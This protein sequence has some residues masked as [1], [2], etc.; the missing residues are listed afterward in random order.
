MPPSLQLLFGPILIGNL[1]NAVL[2]GV[3]AMQALTY[4]QHYRRDTK[5][6]R[7]FILYLFI[8]ETTNTIFAVGMCF[9]PLILKWAKPEAKIFFPKLLATDPVTTVAIATPIQIFTAN[10]IRI[11]SGNHIIPAVVCIL[12][13]VSSGG[14]IWLAIK[15]TIVQRFEKKP[16][17]HWAA[18]C[19]LLS[20]AI[21]DLLITA[22]LGWS[23]A[24]RKTG[25][26]STDDTINRIIRLTIQTGL[27][28]TVFAIL[29]VIFFLVLPK[30]ALNW[31][32]DFALS[33]LYSNA[34]LSSL[35]T[36]SS[37][38]PGDN[39]MTFDNNNP[40]FG[41]IDTTVSARFSTVASAGQLHA[42]VTSSLRREPP[43]GD[44]DDK[45]DPDISAAVSA[46]H[47]P[48]GTLHPHTQC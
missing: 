17:L 30:T 3:F 24:K 18:M 35:N 46:T 22:A 12:A 5:W 28:T 38:S 15:V 10:R 11:I 4:Y 9:E 20:S 41:M 6:L 47:S 48:S 37:W 19:W 43:E 25:F 21:A 40:L 2:Y 45:F 31:I 42:T 7:Y 23:L 34:L 14:G 16:E 27:V 44:D 36:R 1:L 32:V 26:R 33:K 8:A 13:L 29:D 39:S